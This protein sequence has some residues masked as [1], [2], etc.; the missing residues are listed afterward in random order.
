MNTLSPGKSQLPAAPSAFTLT[1]LLVVMATIAL[2]AV[3]LLPALAAS[4]SERAVQ[5]ACL[6]NLRQLSIEMTVYAGNNNGTVVKARRQPGINAIYM[7][8][9]LSSISG[10]TATNIGVLPSNT[11][12]IWTC[13]NRPTLPLFSNTYNQWDIGYQYFGGMT[14]WNNQAAGLMT[15]LSP[16]NLNQSKPWWVI[17]ADCVVECENGW[18]QPTT[19]YDVQAYPDLP[20]HH[21]SD[22]LVPQGGN[23]VFVDGSARWIQVEKMRALTSWDYVNRKFYFYQNPED[24]PSL[25]ASRLS[26]SYMLVNP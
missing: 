16:I 7:Q 2:L 13:P 9:A 1:E 12:S 20:Q 19:M 14:N 18:G 4:S 10:T 24:F 23:E 5:T 3:M 8:I 26:H 15:S 21:G 25:L 11:P 17:A 6:N 22:S